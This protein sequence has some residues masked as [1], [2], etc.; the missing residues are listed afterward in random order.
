MHW[1]LNSAGQAVGI[2][3]AIE[4]PIRGFVGVGPAVPINTLRRALP[5]ML[6]GKTIA[7]PWL[8][9]SGPTATRDKATALGLDAA[10]GV[11]V[12]PDGPAQRAGVRGAVETRGGI[13]G[14][15]NGIAARW[16]SGDGGGWSAAGFIIRRLL[17]RFPHGQL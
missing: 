4:S 9:T 5:E 11:H 14:A 2:N 7:R 15:S 1:I 6:A 10:S 16:R 12:M 8:G 17:S 13:G 3:T